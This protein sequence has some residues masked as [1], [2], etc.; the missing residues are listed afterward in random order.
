MNISL[1]TLKKMIR[2]NKNIKRF[3]KIKFLFIYFDLRRT[4]IR[5]KVTT[6]TSIWPVLHPIILLKI[7]Q[8]LE[9]E[10]EKSVNIVLSSID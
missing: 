6:M 5:V 9:T 8:H 2:I 7:A 1:E 10:K 4:R 3:V